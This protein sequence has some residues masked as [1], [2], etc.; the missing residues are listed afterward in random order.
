M[1][2]RLRVGRQIAGAEAGVRPASLQ[3]FR[4]AP[5][6]AIDCNARAKK[7][8]SRSAER[9]RQGRIDICRSEEARDRCNV[10]DISAGGAC[11]EV[12]GIEAIPARFILHHGGVKKSCRIVWQ[13][14]RRIG[15]S[16]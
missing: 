10:V 8:P 5:L 14:G 15:V 12:H 11:I 3:S 9:A 2:G 16:F 1:G 4:T 6:I 7:V 13:K